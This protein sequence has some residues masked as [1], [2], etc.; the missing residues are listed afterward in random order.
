MNGR[1]RSTIKLNPLE[2]IRSE[3]GS[4]HSIPESRFAKDS[5]VN[6]AAKS[7]DQGK[8]YQTYSM[9]LIAPKQY[10]PPMSQMT[11]LPLTSLWATLR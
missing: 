11:I 4:A 10:F 5:H 2:E 1:R 7:A 3:D 8:K 9:C 6:N